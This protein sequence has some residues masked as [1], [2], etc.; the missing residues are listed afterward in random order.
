MAGPASDLGPR[1]FLDALPEVGRDRVLSVAAPRSYPARAVVVRQG[2]VADALYLVESGSLAVRHSTPAGASVMLAVLGAGDFF[3][4][5]GVL[6]DAQQR[7][8]TIEALDDVVVRV[9]ARADFDALR[10]RHPEVNDFLLIALARNT[11][12]LSRLVAQAHHLPVDRRVARRLLDVGRHF[13]SGVLPVVV[14][15]SQ[16]DVAQLVGA[17]RPTTNQVLKRLEADGVLRLGRGR[18]EIHDVRGLRE[19][20]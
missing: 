20:C 7:T 8:A 19:R 11:E 13:S 16:E 12:R 3:G 4:E 6:L 15:L 18:L 9:L 1:S 17:T 5:V 14:P 10:R 2:D